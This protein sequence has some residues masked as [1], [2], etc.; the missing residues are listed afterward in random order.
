MTRRHCRP[1]AATA[2]LY[3]A[4][5]IGCG[6]P[7]G[8]PSDAGVSAA[9][10]PELI[11]GLKRPDPADRAS[12]AQAIG[13]IGPAAKEAV[14]ALIATLKDRDLGVRAA[15]A[16]SLGQIGPDAKSALPDLRPLTRQGPL[17]EVAAAA[18]KRIEP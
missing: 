6:R 16:Y 9:G 8:V 7:G 10:V 17:R 15:A 13:R 4:L 18:I 1:P 5:L 11:Q 12:S 3:A 14:P 2:L